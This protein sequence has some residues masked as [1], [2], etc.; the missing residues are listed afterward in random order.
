MTKNKRAAGGSSSCGGKGRPAELA[1]SHPAIPFS[2]GD[3]AAYIRK[4]AVALE[5]YMV[6]TF[7]VVTYN[8]A[9]N[10]IEAIDIP[11]S[12]ISHDAQTKDQY[13]VDGDHVSGGSP[14]MAKTH[15]SWL[16]SQAL[17]SGATPEAIRLLEKATGAFTKKQESEMAEKL[18]TKSAAKADKEGLKSAAK[19]A[20]V[21][22]KNA[23]EPPKKRGN[24]EALAKARESKGPDTRKITANIK[25]KDIAAR[26]G[27]KRHEMLTALLS[28]KTVQDFRDK[29]Y[30]AGDLNYAIGANIISVP[31]R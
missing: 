29:G 20:P 24:A 10:R 3:R 18:K 17:E 15:L 9:Y 26:P 22:K 19:S 27:S 28:S 25:A 31:A 13:Y 23:A 1:G 6:P 5:Q 12:R 21:A 11:C 4:A 30:S 14:A 2:V 7:R 16:R 8:I